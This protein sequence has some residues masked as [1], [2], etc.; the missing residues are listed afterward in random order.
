M[1]KVVSLVEFCKALKRNNPKSVNLVFTPY[2]YLL[3]TKKCS[4]SF[5]S[6]SVVDRALIT[7]AAV[8]LGYKPISQE[9]FLDRLNDANSL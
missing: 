8:Q 1:K 9:T 4:F 5:N 3:Y 6:R 7:N 2:S